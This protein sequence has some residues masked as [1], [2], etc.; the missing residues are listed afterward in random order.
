MSR[1][2]AWLFF[3]NRCRTLSIHINILNVP[4]FIVFGF[5]S[6]LFLKIILIGTE[7]DNNYAVQTDHVS[8]TLHV[9]VVASILQNS[10]WVSIYQWFVY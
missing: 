8:N 7:K 2:G 5:S 1:D 6:L 4:F 3:C 10:C 9:D